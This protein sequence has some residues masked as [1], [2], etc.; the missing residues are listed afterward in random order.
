M[1]LI[2]KFMGITALAPWEPPVEWFDALAD[3]FWFDF[4]DPLTVFQDEAGAVPAVAGQPIGC[5]LDKRNGIA[6][7]RT[8]IQSDVAQKPKWDGSAADFWPGGMRMVTDAMLTTE[9]FVICKASDPPIGSLS[10]GVWGTQYSSLA[11]DYRG[12][13]NTARKLFA[14]AGTGLLS[15]GPEYAPGTDVIFAVTWRGGSFSLMTDEGTVSTSC[16]QAGAVHPMV[17][18]TILETNGTPKIPFRGK[19]KS[20]MGGSAM[21]TRARYEELSALMS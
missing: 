2:G 14:R 6:P 16:V 20:I 3:G 13:F 4:G 1:S 17:L 9:Y 15:P 11:V 21:L 19:I 12:G 5:V 8:C 10:E 7:K 18:G